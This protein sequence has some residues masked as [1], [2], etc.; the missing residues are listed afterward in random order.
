MVVY[1]CIH[2][3]LVYHD[4]KYIFWVLIDSIY[5]LKYW[6]NETHVSYSRIHVYI[7]A[8]D[9]R[10]RDSMESD[11]SRSYYTGDHTQSSN[12]TSD[13]I[14]YPSAKKF[15]SGSSSG[16]GITNRSSSSSSSHV[17]TNATSHPLYRAS[18][19]SRGGAPPEAAL[20]SALVAHGGKDWKS[21]V[22]GGEAA[23]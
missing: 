12:H 2:I 18:S 7:L 19:V 3:V 11:S 17:Q 8:T 5:V 10:K 4:V 15:N 6:L 20:S 22:V 13:N 9:K 21:S 23:C 14:G 1:I 16:S